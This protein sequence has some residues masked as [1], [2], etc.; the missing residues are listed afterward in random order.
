MG[1]LWVL[2]VARPWH[3]WLAV[4]LVATGVVLM[5]AIAIGYYRKVLVP[6]YHLLDLQLGLEPAQ[7][8]QLPAGDA[9]PNLEPFWSARAA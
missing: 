3:Y 2:A 7:G 4:A 8:Q 1:A 9:G 6:V 5:L